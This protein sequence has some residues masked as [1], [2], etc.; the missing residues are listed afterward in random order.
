M[1]KCLHSASHLSCFVR[2]FVFIKRQVDPEGEKTCCAEK[3]AAIGYAFLSSLVALLVIWDRQK[4]Q[5]VFPTLF[6]QSLNTTRLTPDIWE[7]F[8]HTPSSS[9]VDTSAGCPLSQLNS[10]TLSGDSV[11]SHHW[12]LSPTKLSQLEALVTSSKLSPVLL[13]YQL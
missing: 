13:T 10:N 5:S 1:F 9:L 2:L 12:G 8:P 4:P 11:R 7:L 6:P 3:L